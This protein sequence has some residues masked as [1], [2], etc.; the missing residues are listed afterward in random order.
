[1]SHYPLPIHYSVEEEIL[2]SYS[3]KVSIL[4][5]VPQIYK[6]YLHV[7]KYCSEGSCVVWKIDHTTYIF[8]YF[9]DFTTDFTYYINLLK[10][11][12]LGPPALDF[13]GNKTTA[14]IDE[15]S[16]ETKFEFIQPNLPTLPMLDPRDDHLPE[17]QNG[18][19]TY[20][21]KVLHNKLV[22]MRE[23]KYLFI[24]GQL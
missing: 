13:N 23:N 21:K 12:I 7:G 4:A 2:K 15:E 5:E 9:C 11:P 24:Q 17:F 18:H 19:V 8:D 6:K 1:M 3:N 10:I 22:F 16:L 14:M 20:W